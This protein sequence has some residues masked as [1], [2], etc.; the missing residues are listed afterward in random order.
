MQ[1]VERN[2]FTLVEVIQQNLSQI[3]AALFLLHFVRI[4]FD[5][6]KNRLLF[7]VA[8]ARVA[9]FQSTEELL[10]AVEVVL[11]PLIERMF[12]ALGTLDAN[13]HE[14][15]RESQRPL[16][17]FQELASGPKGRQRRLI[18]EFALRVLVV[19]VAHPLAVLSV[20][21]VVLTAHGE[22]DPL[23]HVVVGHVLLDANPQPFVPIG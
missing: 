14:R 10:E 11:S 12:V 19:V 15:V 1:F 6:G 7:V 16:F 17:G 23:H 8:T 13:A 9:I 21:L 5:L 22:D 2:D 3:L 18:R 4:D 20:R